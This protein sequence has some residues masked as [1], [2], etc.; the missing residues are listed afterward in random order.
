MVIMNRFPKMHVNVFGKFLKIWDLSLFNRPNT[1]W[2]ILS[3]EQLI[4]LIIDQ[5]FSG[6]SDKQDFMNYWQD[7]NETTRPTEEELQN[8]WSVRQKKI[9]SSYGFPT[10]ERKMYEQN[11]RGLKTEV[12]E[13]VRTKCEG[14]KTEQTC[15]QESWGIPL[16]KMATSKINTFAINTSVDKRFK[17]VSR[18]IISK[19]I[20]ISL[21]RRPQTTKP[22]PLESWD[23][24]LSN[25]AGFVF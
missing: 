4:L 21:N 20:P 14:V 13:H 23:P 24:D 5:K 12:T 25:G 7:P 19:I 2:R 16:K 11:A 22:V 18:Q 17:M 8:R 3:T 1:R 15:R 10:T 6:T 9:R